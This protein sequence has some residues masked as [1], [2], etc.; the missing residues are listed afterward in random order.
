MDLFKNRIQPTI[1]HLGE[2]DNLKVSNKYFLNY[3]VVQ[4]DWFKNNSVVLEDGEGI[5]LLESSDLDNPLTAANNDIGFALNDPQDPDRSVLDIPRLYFLI[6][7]NFIESNE[8][9]TPDA[10]NSLI[11]S[12]LQ[13]SDSES[14]NN[15][16]SLLIAGNTYEGKTILP[17]V[18]Y[19]VNKTFADYLINIDLGIDD[20]DM[21]VEGTDLYEKV[22]AIRGMELPNYINDSSEIQLPWVELSEQSQ[23]N[24]DF[25]FY[26]YLNIANDF[27]ITDENVR[28]FYPTFCRLILDFN[29]EKVF[30][31]VENT[32]YKQVLTYFANSK[33]DATLQGLNLI[34][35]SKYVNDSVK[36]TSSLYS[37][38]C[39][40]SANSA[41]GV[42]TCS[43]IYQD[44]ML[45]YLKQML[46]S[47]TFYYDW[48]FTNEEVNQTLIRCLK[49]LINK[50]K[51]AGFDLSFESY[52]PCKCKNQ[53]NEKSTANYNII[54]KYYTVLSIVSACEIPYNVNKIKVYGSQFGELLPKLQF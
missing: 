15:L 28:N 9:E 49:L 21:L 32:I 19:F 46:G 30:T 36:T 51:E 11:I 14:I 4:I 33:T 22:K 52:S 12:L 25:E 26:Y 23:S 44:S 13:L 43:S 2:N 5:V 8:F 53:N 42:S 38:A 37:S 18:D 31:D 3:N 1:I 54:D 27:D 39:K 20:E 16:N 47:D 34:L 40:C 48:F 10:I 24:I 50:F 35:G 41:S 45:E 29:S 17:G 6:N 7:D